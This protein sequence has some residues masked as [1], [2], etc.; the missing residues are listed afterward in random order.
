MWDFFFSEDFRS[1]WRCR[2]FVC[3][4]CCRGLIDGIFL[5]FFYF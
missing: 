2:V 1:N 4:Q 3:E 5:R